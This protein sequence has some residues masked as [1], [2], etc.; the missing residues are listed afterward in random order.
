M[1]QSVSVIMVSAVEGDAIGFDAYHTLTIKGAPGALPFLAGDG[2]VSAAD[3]GRI[4]GG[5]AGAFDFL[6]VAGIELKLTESAISLAEFHRDD[7]GASI[8]DEAADQFSLGL[9]L[10]NAAHEKRKVERLSP[11]CSQLLPLHRSL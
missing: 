10:K 11:R 6:G 5:L 1:E 2:E 4:G 7:G 8:K 3:D 9:R